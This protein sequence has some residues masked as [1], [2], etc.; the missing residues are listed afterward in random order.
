[1]TPCV[2]DRYSEPTELSSCKWKEKDSN[3]Q[4]VGLQPTALPIRAIFPKEKPPAF[5]RQVVLNKELL[6]AAH[7]LSNPHDLIKTSQIIQFLLMHQNWSLFCIILNSLI[8]ADNI[9]LSPYHYSLSSGSRIW[10]G[11]L[12]VMGPAIFHLINIPRLEMSDSNCATG[13][14]IPYATRAK[15]APHVLSC[16][17]V[18]LHIR[19]AHPHCDRIISLTT[20]DR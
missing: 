14:Q 16:F 11:N 9:F 10:T 4:R 18:L 19:A 7:I 2:S 15:H 12:R 3:L 5:I 20:F 6:L 13:S 17:A 1:M 8:I